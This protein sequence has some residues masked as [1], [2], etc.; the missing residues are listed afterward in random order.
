[1]F[2]QSAVVDYFE[3]EVRQRIEADVK[4]PKGFHIDYGGQFEHLQRA[5]NRLMIAAPLALFLILF[6]LHLSTGSVRNSLI[7]FTGAGIFRIIING[8]ALLSQFLWVFKAL[9]GKL[10]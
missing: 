5:R 7:I 2:Q 10:E 6:F 9:V 3:G 1:M 8:F 4:L